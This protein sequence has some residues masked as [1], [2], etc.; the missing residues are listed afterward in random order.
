[1]SVK[2]IEMTVEEAFQKCNK[3]AKVLVAVQDLENENNEKIDIV[4][5]PFAKK[6]YNKLF[7]DVKT[8]ICFEDEIDEILNLFTEKQNF[9]DLKRIGKRKIILLE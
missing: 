7:H 5:K 6:G 9:L 3:K 1:M 8:V 4:F 2:Y